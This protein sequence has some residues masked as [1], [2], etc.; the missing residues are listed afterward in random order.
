MK[1]NQFRTSY[2]V[3]NTSSK[4]QIIIFNKRNKMTYN[5][6]AF[7]VISAPS[8]VMIMSSLRDMKKMT[9]MSMG[10]KKFLNMKNVIYFKI[11][12]LK[13][14]RNSVEKSSYTILKI[15]EH[16]QKIPNFQRKRA[17]VSK[18]NGLGENKRYVFCKVL[19]Q[20]L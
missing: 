7:D 15:L 5:F 2:N 20:R 8:F 17:D 18:T 4:H 16:F 6:F 1:Q 14:V 12:T 10:V 11:R 19:D 13:L 3:Q 9:F